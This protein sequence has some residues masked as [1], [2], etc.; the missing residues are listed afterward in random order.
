MVKEYIP[1]QGDIIYVNL[2]ATKG[3]EQKGMRP[4][5]VISTNVF[6]KNTKTVIIWPITSNTKD[7]STH[8]LLTESK[9]IFGSVLC[10]HIRSIDYESRTIRFV[11][12]ASEKDLINVIMLVNACIEE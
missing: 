9:T 7:F 5:I 12:K 10:E 3:H 1:K 2:N 6:N 4:A 11:E 8:Y